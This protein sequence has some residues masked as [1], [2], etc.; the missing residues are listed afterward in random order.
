MSSAFSIRLGIPGK[1]G[2]V[3]S[4]QAQGKGREQADGARAHYRGAAR[5]P[6]LQPTLD[7]VSLVDPLFNN[8]ERFEQHSD[9]LQ[10]LRHLHDDI[11]HH[12]RNTRSGSRGAG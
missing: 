8:G 11:R 5:P 9:V 7:L 12:R 6:H 3:N 1:R 10:T 4:A 2:D